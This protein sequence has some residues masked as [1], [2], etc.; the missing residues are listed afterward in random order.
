MISTTFTSGN[1][2]QTVSVIG[3]KEWSSADN[4]Q[5]RIYFDLRHSGDSRKGIAKLYKVIVGDTG[6]DM[7]V[8]GNGAVYGFVCAIGVDSKTKKA[9]VAA[10]VLD[11]VKQL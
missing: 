10:A 11:I 4:S 7:M 6:R 1:K 2:E 3:S 8:A 5:Q 9:A